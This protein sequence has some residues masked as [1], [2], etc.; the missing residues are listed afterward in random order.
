[1]RILKIEFENLNSL[2][3][4]WK[5][6][7]TDENYA[8]NHN[9]FVICGET[10]SG[11][12][13]ILDA[14]TLALYGQTPRHNITGSSNDIM[15]RGASYCMAAVEYECAG[16]HFISRFSQNKSRNGNIQR[17]DFSITDTSTNSIIA[18][19]SNP[20]HF[21]EETQKIIQLSY[22]QFCR[23]IMLAQGEFDKFIN[24][25]PAEKASMLARLTGTEKYKKIGSIIW[26]KAREYE[27]ALKKIGEQIKNIEIISEQDIH[28]KQNEI[29]SINEKIDKNDKIIK[30]IEI[31]ITW[32]KNIEKL[33]NNVKEA[34]MQRNQ[35]FEQEEKFKPEI[36]KIEKA[37][38][39]KNCETSFISYGHYKKEKKSKQDE[40]DKAKENLKKINENYIRETANAAAAE[41]ELADRNNL[42][43][44]NQKIWNKTRILDSRIQDLKTVCEETCQNEQKSKKGLEEKNALLSVLEK[45]I[46]VLQSQ[47]NNAKN[48]IEQN[49]K[50]ENLQ[51]FISALKEKAQIIEK[52][53]KKIESL[54]KQLTDFQYSLEKK[55]KERDEKN[56]KKEEC[57]QNLQ[58]FVSEEYLSISEIIRN[59]LEKGKPCPVCGST[60]HPSCENYGR[61]NDDIAYSYET[62]KIISDLKKGI[63][64]IENIIKELEL[65]ITEINAQKDN[66][67]KQI[68]EE[69]TNLN[70]AIN[71]ANDIL[72]EWQISIKENQANSLAKAIN[73]LEN[74]YSVYSGKKEDLESLNLQIKGYMAEKQSI[75][76]DYLRKQYEEA[77]NS[78]ETKEIELKDVKEQRKSLSGEKDPDFEER[79]L[80]DEIKDLKEKAKKLKEEKD[81]SEKEK[82]AEES[83]IKTLQNLIDEISPKLDNAEKDF[84][85][86][87]RR[88][89]FQDE[90]EFCGSK[91]T[92]SEIEKLRQKKESLEKEN[93]RTA[94]ALNIAKKQLNEE[95]N[96]KLTSKTKTVLEEEKNTLD[97]EITDDK[98]KI[99][100]IQKELDDNEKNKQ[101]LTE[102][103]PKY[104]AAK[105][106]SILWGNARKFIGRQDG[107]DFEIFVQTMALQNLLVKANKYLYD[108]TGKYSLVQ[109]EGE[110][111]FIVHDEN[112]PDSSKDR[113]I[114]SMSGGEKFI[115]S[116]SLALGIAELAS[117]NIR[118]DSLFLDEGFG[119]LSGEPLA[120]SIN[121]LKS[122]QNSGK[123][124]GII[125]H[126]EGVINEFPQKIIAEKKSGG[127]STL[128]G[129]GITK[130][131]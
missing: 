50:D 91:K 55:Q 130:K 51:G 12:T 84:M 123:T 81:K 56:A 34:E 14:I 65:Q 26:E 68:K 48:Y 59:S 126:V 105:E 76:L 114:T 58:K 64:N 22:T 79:K 4:H 117:Q 94:E 9:Q 53:S 13:T 52:T 10:G 46:A 106:K 116:L 42:F 32:L 49:K 95:K 124:L 122:L 99:G 102:M 128:R 82:T 75:D 20:K 104:E 23:S 8:K 39:A 74:R 125:T 6:D 83:K 21:A 120:Q 131:P 62:A 3:G 101:K 16:G 71:E 92:D 66:A 96:K 5:I 44:Q 54:Q 27:D 33:E 98:K 70:N 60:E 67:E 107:T 118:V 111:D 38:K 18:N 100:Y 80:K 19:G 90:K 93:V 47:I 25:K 40:L 72:K 110:V 109:I 28:A 78:H 121:A 115:I 73:E 103:Q 119:T 57:L 43:E 15:H 36:I 89:G 61:K 88:N 86:A 85:E 31:L 63:E 30:Q 69:E 77:K 127:I 35:Y 37:E 11:K 112:F 113:P 24:G 108:I 97:N 1:M 45:N 129:D 17:P 29:N 7:L 2:K 41:K 87:L